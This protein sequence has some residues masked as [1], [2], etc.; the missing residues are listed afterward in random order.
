MPCPAAIDA[1]SCAE[2]VARVLEAHEPFDVGLDACG[3]DL[4]QRGGDPWVGRLDWILRVTGNGKKSVQLPQ[5]D[6]NR[7]QFGEKNVATKA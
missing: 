4:P 2:R 5:A 1:G 6:R 7:P 3:R